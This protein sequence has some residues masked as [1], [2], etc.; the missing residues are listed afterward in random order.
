MTA[1]F[2]LWNFRRRGRS[3]CMGK[4]KEPYNFRLTD[5]E[6]MNTWL[7]CTCY[8][9]L[10]VPFIKGAVACVAVSTASSVESAAVALMMGELGVVEGGCNELSN[11]CRTL[12]TNEPRQNSSDTC[13]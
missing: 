11:H 8:K 6:L 5:D 4:P 13:H 1:D 10:Q 9:M 7:T 3:F 12:G 2:R